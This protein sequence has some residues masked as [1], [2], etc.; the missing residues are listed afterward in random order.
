MEI[1]GRNYMDF[2]EK[3]AASHISM[4]PTDN[5]SMAG[6]IPNAQSAKKKTIMHPE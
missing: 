6:G 3:Y 5:M 2:N 1:N 4:A